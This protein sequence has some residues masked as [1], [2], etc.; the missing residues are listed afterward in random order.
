M[1]DG[2]KLFVA[3]LKH[4]DS[5]VLS[6]VQRKWLDGD[7]V[8]E[9]QF[10]MEYYR[11]HAELPGV[12]TFCDKFKLSEKEADSRPAY[13]LNTVKERFIFAALSDKVPRILRGLK[14][15]PRKGLASM[16]ELV[17]SL[18]VDAIES[19]DTLYSD[20]V[21]QRIKDYE[22][23]MKSL[24]VTYLSMGVE[25]LDETLYGYRKQDLITIGGKAGQGKTWLLVF[26]AHRLAMALAEKEEITGTRPGDILFITNEMGEEEI[27]ERLDCIRFRLPYKAFLKGTLTE[28]EKNRYYRG[29]AA[30][31]EETSFIRLVYSCQTIEELS[32]YIGLYHPSAVFIDGSYLMESQLAEGWE[33]ITYITRNLKLL[34]KNFKVPI[35]N[36]TQLKR[37]SGKHGSKVASDGQEDFAYSSSYSQDSDIALRMFQD[38]D[39]LFHDLVGCE[40]VKGRR[41]EPGTSFVFQN[42]L[43]NMNLS[44][45]LPAGDEDTTPKTMEDF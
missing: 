3:C 21:D 30:L 43:A 38:A 4:E 15:D 9:Y 32:T 40:V 6:A 44:I 17:A 1:T 2:E 29:L 24:G 31:K 18:S 25:V 35:V 8:K 14:D 42:D 34:A 33:K 28:R 22:E 37:G 13:Y 10:L 27:K 7:E 39:M 45:T 23:R 26:L 16:Q 12:K 11:T 41:V 36:T 20:D 5:K 19:S